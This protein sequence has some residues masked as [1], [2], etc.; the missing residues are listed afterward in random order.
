MFLV[1]L[2]Y[3]VA[4]IAFGML[5][6]RLEARVLPDFTLG[7]SLG[8]AQVILSTIASGMMALT[9]IVFSVA[10][11]MVQFSAT[12]YSPR[13]VMW[14]ARS[15]VINHSIGIFTATFLYAIGALAWVDRGGSGRVPPITVWFAI[16]L[17]FASVVFFVLLI[18]KIGML[19][20]TRI[21]TATGDAG[22]T[23]ISRMYPEAGS[24]ASGRAPGSAEADES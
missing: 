8:S 20:V 18:E 22:R 24:A 11:V 10:F 5:L 13:L 14:L 21:L 12:A 7:L 3:A 6:P 1:P 16:L 9:A 4:G 17:L 23:V 15:P 19:Q 2:V